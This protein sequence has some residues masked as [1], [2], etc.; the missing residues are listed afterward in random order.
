MADNKKYFLELGGLQALWNKMKSTFALASDVNALSGTV[1][2]FDAS[3]KALQSDV[4]G[5]EALTLSYAPKAADNYS[6]ASALAATVPAGTVIV[7]GADETIDGKKYLK[8]FYIVDNDKSVQYVGTT[9]GTEDADAVAALRAAVSELQNQIIKT[10]SIVDAEGNVLGG[11]TIANNTLLAVYDDEV[12]VNSDSVN[13]L[14]HR[15]IARKF[16]DLEAMLSS[17]PKFQIE[18]VDTLP[19]SNISLSTIYIVKN[20]SDV[21]N[22]LY[23]EYIYLQNK[24]WESLGE[25]KIAFDNYVTKDF[26]STALNDYATTGYV[27]NAVSTAKTEVLASVADTLKGYATVADIAGF[28]TEANI[29]ASI[30]SGAIGE[31]IAITDA[32]IEALQ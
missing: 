21:E 17:V 11:Y 14:T 29:L 27:D 31:A 15:A 24:G 9:D 16:G 5:V 22:N 32:Q 18:V 23:T 13:A 12:V 8:G 3:I 1:S 6:A 19:E 26:L 28:T 25:Q 7:V 4:D 2:G 20:G 10:A 30:Q